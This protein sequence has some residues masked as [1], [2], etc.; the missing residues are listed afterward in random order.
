MFEITYRY[1]LKVPEG[2]TLT[3]RSQR[4]YDSGFP[5]ALS[6]D[7]ALRYLEDECR[8]LPG[9]RTNVTLYTGYERIQTPKLRQK[10]DDEPGAC[11][12]IEMDRK[13][14]YLIC[15]IWGMTEHNIYALHLTLRALNNIVK[16]GVADYA[17]VLAGF[18]AV[19]ETIH[20]ETIVGD[21]DLLG[22]GKWM[23]VLRLSEDATLEDANTAYRHYAKLAED[24]N[25]LRKL[26]EAIREARAYFARHSE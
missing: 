23:G 24:E 19:K 15:H 25:E 1:P 5:P 7:D 16:W 4:R 8:Q 11:L 18:S 6:M 22:R 2:T 3:S 26:N 17:T 12:E 14:Y 9:A 10:I 21:E 20:S 13:R